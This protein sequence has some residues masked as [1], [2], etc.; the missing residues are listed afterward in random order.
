MIDGS[1][2]GFDQLRQ[3][4][5]IEDFKNCLPER[6][7]TYLNERKVSEVAKAAVLVDE[8]MLTHK[9]SF[10]RP[11]LEKAP[12][13][14]KARS[15]CFESP[16]FFRSRGDRTPRGPAAA[17]NDSGAAAKREGGASFDRGVISKNNVVCFYC[18]QEGHI[19]PNCPK[20]KRRD[21]KP[22]TLLKT[23]NNTFS[24]TPGPTESAAFR[25]F[26][27]DG[28]I[29]VSHS[30]PKVP[31]KILRDTA[32]SQSF[33]LDSILFLDEIAK[34]KANVPIRGFSGQDVNVLLCR[35]VVHS[36]LCS[37]D[38]VVGL[39]PCFPIAGVS[40]FMGN[41]LA[42]GRVLVTP[43]VTPVPVL[44]SQP[45]ELA[46]KFPDVFTSCAV[47]R[48]AYKHKQEEEK[49]DNID[50]SNSFLVDSDGEQVPVKSEGD[51]KKIEEVE[52]LLS[53]KQLIDLQKTDDTL[54]TIFSDTLPNSP[55]SL[56]TG[57]FLKEGLLI[58]KW[59]PLAAPLDE[60]WHS[61]IQ[62]VLPV[63]YR[64]EVLRLAH[65]NPLA[66][67][68]GV[69]KTYDRI[70]RHFFWHGLKK[71]VVRHCQSCH[72]CQLVGKPN[73]TIPPAPLHPIPAIAEPFERVLVDCVGP[74]PRTKAGNKFLVT[75]MCASP[76]FLK[77]FPARKITTPIVVKVL[78]KFFQCSACHELC[79]QIGAV[80]LCR[81]CLL[82][83]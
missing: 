75:V 24:S 65:D 31:I 58:R 14:D 70:L 9:I 72:F 10:E 74:L 73:Q 27:M 33:I 47:T 45:D 66:G 64:T 6:I 52:L 59:T 21:S 12:N 32:T 82:K 63:P 48:A 5:L 22:V 50:L 37:G 53:R 20:L 76:R 77:V 25:P 79:K 43:E 13:L 67:H 30:S 46:R 54:T 15:Y 8:Y 69:R 40:M 80:I 81:E 38:V 55:D 68:L 18:K 62:I 29:S 19:I 51:E 56:S 23:L 71:D 1:V 3:L 41:D 26:I 35:V 49:E 16:R 4:I 57:Y 78:T 17:H 36:E 2:T 11:R 44:C 39:R 7:A 42:G 61:V 28:F 34:I 83:Y 60:D